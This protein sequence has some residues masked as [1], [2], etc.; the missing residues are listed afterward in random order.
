MDASDII[1][2][3]N[4]FSSYEVREEIPILRLF[5]VWIYCLVVVLW[6]N[7]G[8]QLNTTQ[9]LAHFFRFL[10]AAREEERKNKSKKNWGS[11]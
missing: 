5:V 4:H 11:R 1:I 8:H 7:H 2:T 6:V 10:S 3:Q 9:L